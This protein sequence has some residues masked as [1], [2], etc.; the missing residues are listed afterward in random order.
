MRQV[1]GELVGQ[2]DAG[3]AQASCPIIEVLARQG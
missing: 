3:G 1:L 2:C